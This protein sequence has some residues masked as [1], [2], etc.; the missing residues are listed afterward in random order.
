[1]DLAEFQRTIGDTY[2]GSVSTMYR[3]LRAGDEVHERRA[4]ATHPARV[5]PELVA[6]R[7]NA[8]WSWDITKLKG[9][10]RGDYGGTFREFPWRDLRVP[11]W[12]RA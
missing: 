11:R 5:R 7:P 12:I 2:L 3:L 8:V 9:P 1:M 10:R 6:R 4:Q